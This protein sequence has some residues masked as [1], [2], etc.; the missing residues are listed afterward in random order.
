MDVQG[1]IIDVRNANLLLQDPLPLDLPNPGH[2][3]ELYFD[4]GQTLFVAKSDMDNYYHIFKMPH[5]I[6]DYFGLPP[7]ST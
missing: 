5:W 3:E 2:I 7:V 4:G 6:S 1:L